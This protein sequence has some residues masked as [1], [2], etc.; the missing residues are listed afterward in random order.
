MGYTPLMTTLVRARVPQ[1]GILDHGT[2]RGPLGRFL[3]CTR[4]AAGFAPRFAL[5]QAFCWA[6]HTRST[7]REYHPCR[8]GNWSLLTSFRLGR[9][10]LSPPNQPDQP[11]RNLWKASPS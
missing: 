7:P 2:V 11:W 3:E 1:S 10:L 9:H 8:S 4:Y 6:N 5:G